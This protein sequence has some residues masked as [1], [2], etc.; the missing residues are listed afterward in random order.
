[1]NNIQLYKDIANDPIILKKE[2][3]EELDNIL[4]YV[5]EMISKKDYLIYYNEYGNYT[6]IIECISWRVP[7][8]KKMSDHFSG[9]LA[10]KYDATS[11]DIHEFLIQFY[12]DRNK[13]EVFK[14]D[15]N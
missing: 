4:N 2:D 14:N 1:M 8:N 7:L 13:I 6:L 9:I 5:E 10:R 15:K 3:K 12:F 11:V